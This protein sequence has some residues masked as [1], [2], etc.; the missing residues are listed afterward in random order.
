MPMREGAIA[1][2]DDPREITFTPAPAGSQQVR[3]AP[4][5]HARRP[6]SKLVDFVTA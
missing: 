3:L 5:E 6:C 2:S 4:R 1:C